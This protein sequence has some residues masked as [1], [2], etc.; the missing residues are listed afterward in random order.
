MSFSD[1]IVL[2]DMLKGKRE[3][4]QGEK[5]REMGK[6]R[7]LYATAEGIFPRLKY[8]K[9]RVQEQERQRPCLSPS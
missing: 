5:E 6:E 8:K 3:G 4:G 7:N 2:R 1:V 9:D